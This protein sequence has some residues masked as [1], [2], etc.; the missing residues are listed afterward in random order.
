MKGYCKPLCCR[1]IVCD[2]KQPDQLTRSNK[3]LRALRNLFG[4]ELLWLM[5]IMRLSLV[6]REMKFGI[7]VVFQGYIGANFPWNLITDLRR[8]QVLAVYFKSERVFISYLVSMGT[9]LKIPILVVLWWFMTLAK[10][11][12]EHWFFTKNLMYLVFHLHWYTK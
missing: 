3:F 1:K 6:V 5:H 12:K 8:Y 11:K 2:G 7:F 4:L 9:R 10:A